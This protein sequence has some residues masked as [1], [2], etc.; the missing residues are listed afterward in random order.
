MRQT[1]PGDVI[2]IGS[3]VTEQ[4]ARIWVRDTGPGIAPEERERVFERFRTGS[5]SRDG[6]GLGLS[7]VRAIAQAHGGD[8]ELRTRPSAGATFTLV[9]PLD[10]PGEEVEG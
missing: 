6:S 2:A 10:G 1:E 7:I 9:L 8:V 3:T 4:H 5:G